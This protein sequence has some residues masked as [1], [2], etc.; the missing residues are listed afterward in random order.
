M[1]GDDLICLINSWLKLVFIVTWWTE[2]RLVLEKWYLALIAFILFNLSLLSLLL[3]TPSCW[4][5]KCQISV[6]LLY[7]GAIP[8]TE[9][10][11]FIFFSQQPDEVI[12]SYKDILYLNDGA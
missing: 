9:Q 10:I 8:C 12:Q 7:L 1:V 5:Q 4:V 3:Q 2:L 6:T 11:A